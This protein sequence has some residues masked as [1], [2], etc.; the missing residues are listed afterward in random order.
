LISSIIISTTAIKL[1]K[2]SLQEQA[3]SHLIS[4]RDMTSENTTGYFDTI[5]NQTLTF[6][7]NRTII[8][9]MV[10]FK[11]AFNSYIDEDTSFYTPR[12]KEDVRQYYNQDFSKK[13]CTSND[14]T[15]PN[16]ECLITSLDSQPIALQHLFISENSSPI[17][18]KDE[19]V[20]PNNNSLYSLVHELY[21]PHIRDFLQ[22]FEYYDIFLVDPDSGYII[23]SVFKELGYT[24]SLI[25]GPYANSGIAEDFRQANAS[26]NRDSVVLTDFKPYR[27]SHELPASFIASPIYDRD[28]KVGIL[29]FQMPIDKINRVMTHNERWQETGLGQPGETYLVGEDFTMRSQSRFMIEDQQG[30]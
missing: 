19:L 12:M 15:D 16:I 18:E 29:I 4:V 7:N 10:E 2:E 22:R 24:A 30:Y 9:A 8:D 25:D 13:Y 17:G 14:A 6:S 20:K 28:S 1:G 21:H 11:K 27:H 26:G 3:K 5:K 23:Y